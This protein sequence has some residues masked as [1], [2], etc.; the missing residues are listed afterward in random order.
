MSHGSINLNQIASSLAQLIISNR[1]GWIC[2]YD[3]KHVKHH[4]MFFKVYV[5]IDAQSVVQIEL[6]SYVHV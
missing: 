6:F 1:S 3:G 4:E 5:I 2:D